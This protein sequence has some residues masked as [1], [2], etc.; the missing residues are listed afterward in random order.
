MSHKSEK[1]VSIIIPIYNASAFLKDSIGS[2]VKQTYRNWELICV[3]DGSTD[4]SVEIIE[5]YIYEDNRIL[6]LKQKN[7]HAGV[8]RNT[9]LEKAQGDYVIFLDAD[10]YFEPKM[11]EK[12]V[13]TMEQKNVDIIIFNYYSFSGNKLFRKKHKMSYS[14][15][16]RTPLSLKEN[17]FQITIGAPWNKFYSMN[18]VRECKIQFQDTLNSND[19]Y[20]TR[21]TS[22]YCK[23]IYF[24]DERLVNYR[25]NNAKSLQGNVNKSPTSFARAFEAIYENLMEHNLVEVYRKS[26]EQYSVDLC[27]TA[28]TKA[29][30]MKELSAVYQAFIHIMQLVGI[31]EH[32][33]YVK[34]S[35]YTD[36]IIALKNNDM[37]GFIA[38][39]YFYTIAKS[40]SK[41]TIEYRIGKA[42][43]CRMGIKKY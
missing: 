11:L 29:S 34:T 37:E 14:G 17:I 22:V 24:L 33:E 18:F 9:G 23:N 19:I 26:I 31:S 36:I 42:I 32:S 7:M 20:F 41:T 28:L 35:N 10:D 1:L 5:K 25:V 4:D 3:D 13:Y 16:V 8:A 38:A 2:I 15:E 6:L 27:I 40:V 43:L 39:L 21:L 30:T 12:L